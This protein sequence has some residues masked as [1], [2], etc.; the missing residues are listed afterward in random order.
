ML[1]RFVFTP[2]HSFIAN[3]HRFIQLMRSRKGD[4]KNNPGSINKAFQVTLSR[5]KKLG[6]FIILAFRIIKNPECGKPPHF[7]KW[8]YIKLVGFQHGLMLIKIGGRISPKPGH[9]G[10]ENCTLR[11]N[12]IEVFIDI[13]IW[14][15]LSG[16]SRWRLLHQFGKKLNMK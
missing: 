2:V 6:L 14:D 16:I 11:W 9:R 8:F 3:I 5:F 13:F 10:G 1:F 15:R 7:G 4:R 12:V